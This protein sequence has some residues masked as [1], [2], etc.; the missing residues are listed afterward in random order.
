MNK[1]IPFL[2]VIALV[3]IASL[4]VEH[5]HDDTVKKLDVSSDEVIK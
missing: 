4:F 3:A 5:N 1:F 2:I